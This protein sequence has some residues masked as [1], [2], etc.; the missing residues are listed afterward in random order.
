MKSMPSVWMKAGMR[1]R[2]TTRPLTRPTQRADQRGR[3]GCATGTGRAAAV[4]SL[5]ATTA[6]R[7][8]TEP[9]ER[10]NSPADEQHRLADGDDADEG[11]DAEDG[12]D[13]ALGEEGGLEEVEEGDEEDERRDDADLA[14]GKDADQPVAKR[15]A[16]HR[17]RG[18]RPRRFPFSSRPCHSAWVPVASR[19]TDRDY[20]IMLSQLP[21]VTRMVPLS[22]QNARL[23]LVPRPG[24]ELNF[25][26]ARARIACGA[27]PTD[28]ISLMA[29][30]DNRTTAPDKSAASAC[31]RS[32]ARWGWRR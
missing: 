19:A 11:D 3:R 9:T 23:N 20:T 30:R 25:S 8:A 27:T 12:A 5:A 7:P 17:H 26:G 24:I 29:S 32:R 2:T 28:D 22:Y 10:S 1:S 4:I 6:E 13:V 21:I 31:A 14:D 15:L 18:S 16:R